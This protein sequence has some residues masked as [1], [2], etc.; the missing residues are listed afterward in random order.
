VFDTVGDETFRRSID[1]VAPAGH[2]VTILAAT[3]GD[4]AT[5][6]LYR[7]IT[8]HYEFMGVPVA[9]ELD[10]GHQGSILTS[11]ARLVD[12][13]LVRPHVSAS[14]PLERLADAH[15]QIETGRTI[16]K[17]SVVVRP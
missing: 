8:V 1:C 14:Y 5:T 17:L 6:L 9:Y 11:I 16:G 3:P 10:P 7:S 12:R 15:R 4:R 13:G 2:I